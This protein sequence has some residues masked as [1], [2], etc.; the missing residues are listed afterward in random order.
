MAS[1]L[2]QF[3]IVRLSE[4]A[5]YEISI[6]NSAAFMLLT[7]AVFGGGA[8]RDETL[9]A[10]ASLISANFAGVILRQTKFPDS[11][12]KNARFTGAELTDANL[13]GANLAGADFTDANLDAADFRGISD[14]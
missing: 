5:G 3:E 13:R 8:S 12:L 7:G 14:P 4:F 6:T 1:P 11:H 2:E 9:F 10:P